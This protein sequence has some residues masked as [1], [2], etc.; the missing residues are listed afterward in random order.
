VGRLY[1]G[2]KLKAFGQ[3]ALKINK[4]LLRNVCKKISLF[5]FYAILLPVLKDP[6]TKH[7]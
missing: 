5:T 7:T 2:G 6:K 1:R 3:Q 4:S